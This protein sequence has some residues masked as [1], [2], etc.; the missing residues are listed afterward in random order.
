MAFYGNVTNTSKTTFSFDKTYSNRYE[1]DLNA[2]RDGVFVGRYVLVDYDAGLKSA[3]YIL[4]KGNEHL[5]LYDNAETA[6]AFN[7]YTNEP[8]YELDKY[9]NKIYTSADHYS[10]YE[11][12]KDLDN[13]RCLVFH[14][15]HVIKEC[16]R[17]SL[18][19]RATKWLATENASVF[20]M[21][22]EYVDKNAYL[23]YWEDNPDAQYIPVE[24]NEF[25][26]EPYL[27]YYR[28]VE[29]GKFK[30]CETAMFD[31]D[32]EYYDLGD[33]NHNKVG[34]VDGNGIYFGT[35]EP[36]FTGKTIYR[37]D[38]GMKYNRNAELEYWAIVGWSTATRWVQN[39]N[40]NIA[41]P[42]NNQ[43]LIEAFIDVP[44]WGQ[45]A[46]VKGSVDTT[47]ELV[48]KPDLT[49]IDDYYVLDKGV[50]RK[51]LEGDDGPFYLAKYS[52]DLIPVKGGANYNYDDDYTINMTIDRTY[53]GTSRGYDSTVWQKMFRNGRDEYVMV[54][55][56]NSVVPTFDV[57]ADA[58]TV[59]PLAPHFDPD[60]SNV[61]YR[62]HVQPA[63]GMRTKFADP[64]L[65]LPRINVNGQILDTEP[66]Y[67]RI[68]TGENKHLVYPSDQTVSLESDFYDKYNDEKTHKYLSVSN[69]QGTWV[70]A[71]PAKEKAQV[72]AAIYY[73]KMGFSPN[74][75]TYSSDLIHEDKPSYNSRVKH[76]GWKNEDRFEVTPTG[77][78]GLMYDNHGYGS[79]TTISVD[80]QEFSVMLPSLGDTVAKIWDLIYGG[81]DT[82]EAIRQTH[83]RNMDVAW[84]DAR[85]GQDRKGLRMVGTQAF[86][87][88]NK[89]EVN[90]IAGCINSV[91]DL[92]GMIISKKTPKE[93][94]ESITELDE[95]YI[96]YVNV[97]PND[98]QEG[99]EGELCKYKGQF[100]AKYKTYEYIPYEGEV[101][102]FST[103]TPAPGV[104]LNNYWVLDNGVYR[105]AKEGDTGPFYIKGD[106]AKYD[107]VTPDDKLEAFDGTK[108]Y[109][110]DGCSLVGGK[111]DD[112]RLLES[113]YVRETEYQRDRKY[114][115]LSLSENFKKV[116]VS[117][118]F[119][120]GRFY[121][122]EDGDFVLSWE[123][124]ANPS[125]KYYEINENRLVSLKSEGFDNVYSPGVYF[126]KDANGDY[127]IDT[128]DDGHWDHD[129]DGAETPVGHYLAIAKKNPNQTVQV[130]RINYVKAE[131]TEK[132]IETFDP[133][134]YYIE[135]A[136]DVYVQNTA[137]Y[138]PNQVYYFKVVSIVTQPTQEIYEVGDYVNLVPYTSH[139]F[140][141]KIR[142]QEDES[143]IQKYE[144]LTA[145]RIRE[146]VHNEEDVEIVA[147]GVNE[148]D[149][150]QALLSKFDPNK[151]TAA[152]KQ[153][154]E[155]WA[156]QEQ[157][158]F[159][160]PGLYHYIHGTD[161]GY[162]DLI[163]DMYATMWHKGTYYKMIK[164]P[165]LVTKNFYEPHKYY[166]QN[167]NGEYVLI[168]DNL[169][170]DEIKDLVESGNIFLKDT[171]YVYE[172]TSGTFPK[173]MEWNPNVVDVPDTVTLAT[174]KEKV[175]LRVLE[176]FARD[177]NT[178]H[179]LILYINRLLMSGDEFTRDERTLQ[180]AINILNDK[181]AQ[182]GSMTPNEVMVVDEMGRTQ[183]AEIVT[184]Q[185]DTAN[186]IK[187]ASDSP[188]TSINADTYGKVGKLEDMRGQWIT[189][190]VDPDVKNPKFT[191]HHNFQAV[192]NTTSSANMNKDGVATQDAAHDTLDF[193]TPIVD[194]MGHV[195]GNNSHKV[196]L[197]YGFKSITTNG[198]VEDTVRA[199]LTPVAGTSVAESTQDEF[200]LN[201]GNKWIR[202][203]MNPDGDA[204]TIAHETHS[205][206][207][208]AKSDTDLNSVGTFTVQ[209]T[210]YDEAGHITHNQPHTYKLPF[211]FKTLSVG[212]AVT[213]TAAGQST[214]GDI[215][216]NDHVAKFTISPNNRWITMSADT[217]N[218]VLSI[219]HAYAGAVSQSDS[220]SENQTPKFG[221]SFNIPYNGFDQAGHL[222]SFGMRTVTLPKPSLNVAT[223]DVVSGLVLKDDTTGQFEMTKK[224]VGTFV[225]V[226]YVAN[227]EDTS[228]ISNED[229]INEAFAKL[230]A[231]TKAEIKNR[232]DALSQEVEDR[233]TAIEEAVEKLVS[234]DNMAE[235][236]PE[237]G[238]TPT[239]LVVGGVTQENGVVSVTYRALEEA[240]L[241]STALT[242]TTEFTYNYEEPVE[243]VVP[244]DVLPDDDTTGDDTT[245][246]NGAPVAEDETEE[247][248]II[249]VPAKTIQ[250]LFDKVAALEARIYELEHPT[251]EEEEIEPP[252]EPEEPGTDEGTEPTV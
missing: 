210:Q 147:F 88:Y 223:G 229:T 65:Q 224:N 78:S 85:K 179:G 199:Q 185:K 14:P 50:Y 83:K 82:N 49:K 4:D 76:S 133:S 144:H 242:L 57:E 60:S 9:K 166:T 20:F 244:D 91:H 194:A 75:V 48:E 141:C 93:L 44:V 220:Q 205:L 153:D 154:P 15:K 250:W 139:T 137:P 111:I 127:I 182:F 10:F 237:D 227:T 221:A 95:D 143:K 131:L 23:K 27:F 155:K 136:S 34:I 171:Y 68:P 176:G 245:G 64:T 18:Y 116:D 172:D 167:P 108:Y 90:T 151:I 19:V 101:G 71:P 113:D 159:Y 77:R 102:N 3:S 216:A 148:L 89:T 149:A 146:I 239:N 193:Y 201:T 124:E 180:G 160:V 142:N 74:V 2:N 218:D 29:T 132:D 206:T 183:S 12:K 140:Y 28:D 215:V 129:N 96:Y 84:E 251:T 138:D 37:I 119:T 87:G 17:E 230:Q 81:R 100:M 200:T 7:L 158:V 249:E 161:E 252:V 43:P 189:I 106:I 103:T 86:N 211:N 128:D 33:G 56:L 36:D 219:G 58:P 190:N 187:G 247:E 5:Y 72:P 235:L 30:L 26:Y 109:Y 134:A 92:M 152:Q 118:E 241:P 186:K 107:P 192:D 80:T 41:D 228:D 104:D 55:E 213:G 169:S 16:N 198:S 225:I 69:N 6:D 243:E 99:L 70:D 53:Y 150:T 177:M 156:C 173:G 204:M 130:Q 120:P 125:I 52:I 115:E 105:P 157:S 32:I 25:S 39:P 217:T 162:T 126:Y 73:N 40:Y 13:G 175:E 238:E 222:S 212:A 1:M 135:S 197:P 191:V 47:Y 234:T 209:D 11:F 121:Y 24:L 62:L 164:E 66:A 207:T 168:K 8:H 233:N 231:Q 112:T 203:A 174:R 248:E 38:K 114:Y 208:S 188:N 202:T 195:V 122:R 123:K 110:N 226:D 214:I 240:D 232:E 46:A 67:A 54:A 31:P 51:A 22:Y 184:Y 246:G 181:I 21:G 61:F 98:P 117:Q 178:I 79:Q 59:V 42:K 145:Q 165:T 63:W 35:G 236:T 45:L 97:Q 170:N 94:A 163:L 196:T